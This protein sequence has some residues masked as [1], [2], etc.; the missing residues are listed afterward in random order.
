MSRPSRFTR[1]PRSLHR[2]KLDNLALLP[3][4][5]LPH[6]KEWQTLANDLPAGS[7]LI[8]LPD[9]NAAQKTVL[10]AVAKL[11][12][13]A[14]HQVRVVPEAEMTRHRHAVQALKY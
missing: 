1:P 13:A 8:V 11:V 3:G 4:S 6:I 7:V 10:L 14:G 12:A 5:S 9:G 2:V